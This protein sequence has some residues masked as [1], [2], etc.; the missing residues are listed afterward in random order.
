MFSE[1]FIAALINYV[2]FAFRDVV[3]V[4]NIAFCAFADGNDS[5]GVLA[6]A[7]EFEVVDFSVP[8]AVAFGEAFEDK[9]VDSDYGADFFCALDI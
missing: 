5:V 8:E 2:N 9:V 4:D 6:G 3:E 1:A 7:A